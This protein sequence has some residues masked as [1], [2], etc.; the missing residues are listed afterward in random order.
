MPA[1][2]KVA[3]TS[4]GLTNVLFSE[5]ETLRDG[6]S[7]PQRAKAVASLAQNICSVARLDLDYQRLITAK[8]NR[9]PT[10][11]KLLK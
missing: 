10:K 11:P 9:Q 8:T 6:E 2:K 7:D 3:R 5:I 4:E 1:R